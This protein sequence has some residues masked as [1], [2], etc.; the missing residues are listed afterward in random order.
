MGHNLLNQLEFAI[1]CYLLYLRYGDGICDA[2]EGIS[3][4][5][6]LNLNALDA[7]SKGM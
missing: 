1:C 4:D 5:F 3:S 6:C 7:V 2:I